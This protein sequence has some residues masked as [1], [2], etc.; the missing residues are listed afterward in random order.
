LYVALQANLQTT[1]HKPQLL[2]SC[3]AILNGLSY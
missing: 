2:I 1:N 3:P